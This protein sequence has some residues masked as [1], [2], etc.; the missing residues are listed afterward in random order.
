MA[1]QPISKLKQIQTE[2]QDFLNETRIESQDEAQM[3]GLRKFANFCLLVGNSFVR[4]RC[5]VRAAALA[6]TTLLAFIPLLAVGL[7]VATSLLK[8]ES[9]EKEIRQLTDQ[10]ISRMVPQL[11]LL[12]RTNL[13]VTG[14][15]TNGAAMDPN[16]MANFVDKEVVNQKINEFIAN[17]Q[18]GALGATGMAGLM[19]VAILML[20][21]IETTFNDIWG[22]TR[23]RSW[24]ARVVQYWATITLGPIVLLLVMGLTTSGHFAVMR[25]WI[26]RVPVLGSLLFSILPFVIL[27]GAFAV[28]YGYMPNTR[29]EWRAALVGGLVGGGLWQLSNVFNVIYMSKV[30]SNSK[31]YGSLSVVPIFLIGMYFSWMIMLFGAQV[32]YAF[33]NR[34]AY[35]QA[36]LTETVN[37]R[38]REFVGL[39]LA[40][41]IGL[42][43]QRGVPAP[44]TIALA[45]HLDV[46]SRLAAQIL[47]TLVNAKLLQE[48]AG[49]EIGYTP[50]RPLNQISCQDILQALRASQGQ[51]PATR[52]EPTRTLVREEFDR[53]RLAEQAAAS[54]AT[55]QTLVDRFPAGPERL[56]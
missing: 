23:G 32:A 27:I 12:N 4:N 13:S 51:E 6:Y 25:H 10:F 14:A 9:G 30:V 47:Q 24:V 8:T 40:T 15:G 1:D 43:F 3:S 39:R 38:G 42:A 20:S 50:A 53:I 18:S 33:Q 11:N 46:P 54:T 19:L 31:I 22:V 37:Q 48:V 2:A 34:S 36:K 28:F 52:E 41:N 21:S 5:P 26:E 45:A 49:A 29:V 7:S 56:S 35:W 16:A 55:L 44:S 17:T